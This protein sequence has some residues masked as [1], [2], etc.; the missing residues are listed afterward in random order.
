MVTGW[1]RRIT[2]FNDPLLVSGGKV[3]LTG[4][5]DEAVLSACVKPP[6]LLVTTSR[7]GAMGFWRLE[8]GQ[9]IRM[10]RVRT[11]RDGAKQGRV[12]VETAGSPSMSS[13]LKT[14]GSSSS[15]VSTASRATADDTGDADD[16]TSPRLPEAASAKRGPRENG[17]TAAVA[18]HFLRGRPEAQRVGTLLV[19]TRD[20]AVQL[21]CTHRVPKYVTRFVAAHLNDDYVTA[22]ASDPRSEYLF[23]SFDSGYLKTWYVTNFG[24]RPRSVVRP[25]MP[26]LRLRF[27][28]LLETFFVGRAAAAANPAGPMLVNSYRAHVRRIRHVEYVAGLQLVVTSGADKSV[29]VW[30]LAGHYVGTLGTFPRARR[31]QSVPRTRANVTNCGALSKFTFGTLIFS[32]YF[33]IKY[34]T[35]N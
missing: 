28:F 22:M 30:T 31:R 2:E 29:R 35:K 7:A 32:H 8:T 5:K 18:S 11:R 24:V 16:E 19:A 15:V 27:P 34:F 1:D 26:V 9:L 21:W 12:S 14:V 17:A 4:H 33:V 10:Y 13:V 25:S 6:S 3:W 23:T 20:G